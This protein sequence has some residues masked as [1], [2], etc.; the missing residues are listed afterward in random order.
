MKTQR[1]KNTKCFNN[2]KGEKTR[3]ASK[4]RWVLLSHTDAELKPS[5]LE[6]SKKTK[7]ILVEDNNWQDGSLL[8]GV[9]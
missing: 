3:S 9:Y 1:L 5:V 2:A 4:E 6:V 7:E 8:P